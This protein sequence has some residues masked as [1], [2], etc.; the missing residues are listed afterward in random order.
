M[1][2]KHRSLILLFL[3]LSG[4]WGQAKFLC[5]ETE[6]VPIARL[7]AN[8][9][10]KIQAG[11]NGVEQALRLRSA[12]G[13]LHSMAYALKTNALAVDQRTGEP[14][15]GYEHSAQ[16]GAPETVKAVTTAGQELAAKEH[17]R[18]AI[19][20][21]R[22]AVKL[23][24][25]HLP[26]QLGLGWCLDQSGDKPAAVQHYRLA[27]ELA[28]KEEAGGFMGRSLTEEIAGYLL[29]LLDPKRDAAAIAQ[30]EQRRDAMKKAPRAVTP[31]LIPLDGRAGLDELVDPKAGVM[32]DLDGSGLARPWGWITSRAGW[33]VYDPSGRGQITSALQL[34]G[35]VTFWLFWADGFDAL[36]A[37]D[38]NGDGWLRGDELQGLAIW[39]DANVN[40]VSEPGEV[41]PLADWG[42]VGLS[43]QR[44]VHAS[45]IPFSPEGV[46]FQDG[47]TRPSYDWIARSP[48][49]RGRPWPASHAAP[50]P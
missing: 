13:R 14:W 35:S 30:V 10:R 3:A 36:A 27:L 18:Q 1:K 39:R 40:G 21:Y 46:L 4:A 50:P 37:L 22:Q 11:T 33:L 43:C 48:E 29:P 17:L 44:A 8:F 26:S 38:D 19:E 2:A 15:Y 49:E 9:E 20:Q 32:F 12:L 25:T 41:R 16:I 23:K 31:L 42:I 6:Q 5:V 47:T 45:G 7:I 34:V 28:W 24:P